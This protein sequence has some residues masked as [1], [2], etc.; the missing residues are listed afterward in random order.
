MTSFTVVTAAPPTPN[1]DLHL[2]HLSGPYSGADIHVRAQRLQGGEALYL[3][4]SDVNQS[5]VPTK[6]ARD[7][8]APLDMAGRFADEIGQ[9]FTSADI[10]TDSYVRP[11]D[12]GLHHSIV[13]HFFAQLHERG[14]LRART[15]MALFCGDCGR[16]LFEAHVTGKCPHLRRHQ[17]RE[18]LRELRPAQPVSHS[19]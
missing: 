3:T 7:G 1:G 13:C 10:V 14:A 9:I 5:Y 6:A 11:W 12:S 16:Y 19:E 4:G 18:L 2:G 8:T 17:R 15:E